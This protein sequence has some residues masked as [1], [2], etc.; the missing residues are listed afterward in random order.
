M[1]PSKTL[2]RGES[3]EA[4]KKAC[5]SWARYVTRKRTSYD[6]DSFVVESNWPTP[7]PTEG[8]G[9]PSAEF[10]VMQAGYSLPW[11]FRHDDDFASYLKVES[12]LLKVSAKANLTAREAE[13]L[14]EVAV[15]CHTTGTHPE[16][17]LVNTK[18]TLL[19]VERFVLLRKCPGE[20]MRRLWEE[21]GG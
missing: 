14:R 19:W 2:D 9:D 21:A 8:I 18:R 3:V 17:L 15:Y 6:W 12:A 11:K 4:G 1:N 16:H 20:Y 7:L 5:D 13:A 10:A